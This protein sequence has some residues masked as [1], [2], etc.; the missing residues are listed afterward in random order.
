LVDYDAFAKRLPRLRLGREWRLSLL[1]LCLLE[2]D[3]NV[4]DN[5]YYAD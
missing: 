4:D 3:E 2:G 1:Q 5:N